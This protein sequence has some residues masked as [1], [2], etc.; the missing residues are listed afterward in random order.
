M[1]E[2]A[3]LEFLN[4]HYIVETTGFLVGENDEAI[5]LSQDIM[6][7]Y[8]ARSV[9]QIPRAYVTEIRMLARVAGSEPTRPWVKKFLKR[10]GKKAA[11]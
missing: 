4:E 7:S 3:L 6:P 11:R 9:I 2:S 10:K 1:R 8:S 5:V